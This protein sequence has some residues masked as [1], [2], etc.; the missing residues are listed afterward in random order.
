VLAD[1]P[2]YRALTREWTTNT[3]SLAA[4][5]VGSAAP[6]DAATTAEIVVESDGVRIRI[7]SQLA[8][9]PSPS[10]LAAVLPEGA[11][12]T[13]VVGP[14]VWRPTGVLETVAA[15][16]PDRDRLPPAAVL[17]RARDVAFG[18]YPQ[19]GQSLWQRW[20]AVLERSPATDKALFAAGHR[21]GN[22]LRKSGG[23]YVIRRGDLVLLA[24]DAALVAAT[25]ARLEAAK[26]TTGAPLVTGTYDGKIAAAA[27]SSLSNSG[28]MPME[29]RRAFG[30]IAGAIRHASYRA[31]LDAATGI[32]TLTGR[33]QLAVA[34]EETPAIVDGWLAAREGGNSTKLP[35]RLR[36]VELDTPLAYE[37]EVDDAQWFV[38]HVVL[39]SPRTTA[40][41]RDPTHAVVEVRPTTVAPS[42]LGSADRERHTAPTKAFPSRDPAITKLLRSVLDD[43]KTATDR[44]TK[45]TAFVHQRIRYAVTPQQPDGVE[46]LTTGEGDCSEYSTLTVTLLRA[47]GIPAYVVQ[48]MLASDDSMVA[49][50]WV[51]FHDG[52]GWREID[53]TAGM[54]NVT[55]GHIELSLID[56]LSLH[57]LGRL[58]ISAVDAAP[59]RGR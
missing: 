1:D 23:L 31:D 32:L 20:V 59:M 37:V 22:E 2:G 10:R 44:A 18:W 56:A 28:R 57:S 54:M 16:D 14:E 13:I 33:V 12:S 51:A 39:P 49:H 25:L 4:I 17:T 36:R 35:R 30:M 38:D 27:I 53:P 47:A 34:D 24:T 8:K 15:G 3:A 5:A 52:H 58:K 11:A 45:I 9:R 7:R 55:A 26:P 41:V 42:A 21:V 19:P 40:T 46:I 48:G 6:T 43:A 50:A 29:A